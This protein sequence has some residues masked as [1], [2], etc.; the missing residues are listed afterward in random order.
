MLPLR[1]LY[2]AALQRFEVQT[3][4]SDGRLQFMRNR[5]D[6][7]PVL[8]VQAYLADQKGCLLYTSRCV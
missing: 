4:G 8:F 3:N 1:F 5:V 6:E 7:T 2:F